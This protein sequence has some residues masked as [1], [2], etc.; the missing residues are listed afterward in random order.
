MQAVKFSAN[1]QYIPHK[2]ILFTYT[3][4]LLSIINILS[5]YSRL[6][7]WLLSYLESRPGKSEKSSQDGGLNA[8]LDFQQ[9]RAP[10]FH[11]L[12]RFLY[13]CSNYTSYLPQA[14]KCTDRRRDHFEVNIEND[15]HVNCVT[16][17]SRV[18]A[19]TRAN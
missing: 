10:H 16:V 1:T 8:G 7:L 3:Y 9:E 11:P 4:V 5:N 14:L 13:S 17:N 6:C 18:D 2:N 15:S 19:T 12:I